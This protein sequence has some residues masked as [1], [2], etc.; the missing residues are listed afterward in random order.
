[1]AVWF[2]ACLKCLVGLLIF[3]GVKGCTIV[4]YNNDII[5][6]EGSDLEMLYSATL[7]DPLP[8]GAIVAVDLYKVQ[9]SEGNEVEELVMRADGQRNVEEYGRRLKIV[10]QEGHESVSV[11]IE[12]S[13]AQPG[14][15]GAYRLNFRVSVPQDGSHNLLRD[16]C[17]IFTGI[18]VEARQ[19]TTGKTSLPETTKPAERA[20][21]DR[22][23]PPSSLPIDESTPPLT[24]N[25]HNDSEGTLG[26]RNLII[27][28]VVPVI[29]IVLAFV[30][31]LT[32]FIFF[33]RKPRSNFAT[34]VI[35]IPQ[36][37]TTKV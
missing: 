34:H 32:I 14:H 11:K 20:N 35:Y 19:T 18:R 37:N 1:M 36:P 31:C 3:F 29:L 6:N 15:A 10:S 2:P 9:T 12:Q 33:R 24:D 21:T 5:V 4:Q 7:D 22:Q 13:N 17:K 25:F 26:Q 23:A 16:Q 28:A 27:I 30:S 8:A